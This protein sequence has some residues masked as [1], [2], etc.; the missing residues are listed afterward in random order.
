[1][2]DPITE[3]QYLGNNIV[4]VEAA[5][6]DRARARREAERREAAAQQAADLNIGR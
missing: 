5:R 6:A 4:D 1:M 3:A 2:S